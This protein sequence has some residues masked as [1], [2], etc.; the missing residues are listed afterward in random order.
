[1]HWVK[2]TFSNAVNRGQ[3]LRL[4]YNLDQGD[5]GLHFCAFESCSLWFFLGYTH[6]MDVSIPKHARVWHG[7]HESTSN[8]LVLTNHRVIEDHPLWRNP[9]MQMRAVQTNAFAV[10]CIPNPSYEVQ[11]AA[12]Q[13]DLRAMRLTYRL[14][15]VRQNPM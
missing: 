13:G 11:L 5:K 3:Q 2:L 8:C 15:T 7:E 1:M 4:G 6:I 10:A 12:I 14:P 9:T